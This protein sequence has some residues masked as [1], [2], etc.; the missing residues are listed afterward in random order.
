[1]AGKIKTFPADFVVEEIPLYEPCGEGEHLYVTIRKTK[2]SHDECLRKIAKHF[3]VSIRD[4]GSAGR[5]DL[6]AV[7]TQTFSVYLRGKSRRFLKK[8]GTLMY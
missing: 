4:I 5:K 7:T 1:M 8:L 2:M 3:A 6:Q